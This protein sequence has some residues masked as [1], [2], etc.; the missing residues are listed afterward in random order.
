MA[1][2]SKAENRAAFGQLSTDPD[3][4]LPPLETQPTGS[5]APTSP[6]IPPT[7]MKA[8]AWV[9]S[10]WRQASFNTPRGKTGPT[11]TSTSCAYG[12]MQIL[13]DMDI[14]SEP[15]AKQQKT[16]TDFI[17]NIA[18][19]AQ[20]LSIKWNFAPEYLPVVLP[21]NPRAIEDWYYAVWAYHCF[22][23]VCQALSIHNNPEDPALKWPRPAYNSP[24]QLNSNGQFSA[25]D[26]PYQELVYG[27]IANP[28]VVDGRPLWPAL[29]VKLPARGSISFPEPG[30]FLAA[31]NTTDPT[32]ADAP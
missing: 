8:I 20:L 1:E 30:P 10:G 28:P 11:I 23:E 17:N 6:Y 22:G 18:A 13:T 16:G 5:G 3:Y 15:T 7:L 19:A 2:V 27:A 4:K 29:P 25:T 24:D 12:V 26:Y 32:T 14:D 21:R 31:G 9:E